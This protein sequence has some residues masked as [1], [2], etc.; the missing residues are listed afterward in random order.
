M[1]MRHID[2]IAISGK[3]TDVAQAQQAAVRAHGHLQDM[4]TARESARAHRALEQVAAAA[5][6]DRLELTAH[7]EPGFA[8]GGGDGGDTLTDENEEPGAVEAAPTADDAEGPRIDF[9]A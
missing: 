3:T 4:L 1:G 7:G 5:P 6:E 8:G 9:M 2:Q